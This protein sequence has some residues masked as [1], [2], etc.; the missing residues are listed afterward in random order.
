MPDRKRKRVPDHMSNALKD[1]SRILLYILAT[2]KIRI[3][4]RG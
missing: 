4:K 3:I 1:I 2:R